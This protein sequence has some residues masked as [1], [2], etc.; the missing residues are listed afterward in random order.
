MVGEGGFGL[1][2]TKHFRWFDHT[3]KLLG[4]VKTRDPIRRAYFGA[5]GLVI[6][7]RTHRGIVESAQSWW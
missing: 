6:E 3:G 1:R 2:Q 7:T 4:E 5:Q